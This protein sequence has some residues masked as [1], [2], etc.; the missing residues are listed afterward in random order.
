MVVLVLVL[1]CIRV[2]VLVVE[3]RIQGKQVLVLLQVLGML[4]VVMEPML[5]SM[6]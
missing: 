3:S 2:P 1:E 5:V 6:D 4:L